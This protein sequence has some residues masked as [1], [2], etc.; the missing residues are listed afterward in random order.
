M[1]MRTAKEFADTDADDD[2]NDPDYQQYVEAALAEDAVEENLLSL[3][4][5]KRKVVKCG[6]ATPIAVAAEEEDDLFDLDL[7]EHV[8]YWTNLYARQSDLRTPFKTDTS[9][10]LVFLSILIYIGVVYLP[11]IEDYWTTGA[12]VSQVANFTSSKRFWLMRARIHFTGNQ[13]I[14]GTQDRL[15]K[16]RPIITAITKNHLRIPETPHQSVDEVMVAYKGTR[17][18]N[19]LQYIRNK[20]DKWGYKFFCRA[21]INGIIHD[22]LMYQGRTTFIY[23][24]VQLPEEEALMNMSGKWSPPSSGQS[25]TQIRR[26]HADNFFTSI[27][28]V[29]HLRDT[30][31]SRY[32]GTARA[33][34]RKLSRDIK[35]QP[36][37]RYKITDSSLTSCV[38]DL[39]ED[40]GEDGRK[41]GSSLQ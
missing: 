8:V 19:L 18:G 5:K 32:V 16:V 21:R 38:E 2:D 33:R 3:P 23:H 20:P 1:V 34:V 12:G 14:T 17:A 40:Q 10:I 41:R 27:G 11:S 24:T 9:E 6:R 4:R 22:L 37:S 28:L 25:S 26:V 39:W 7:V 29:E 36:S 35:F 30:Y 13:Q 31:Q 15:Y